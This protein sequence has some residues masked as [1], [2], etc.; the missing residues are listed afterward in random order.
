M[1]ESELLAESFRLHDG[2]T[3]YRLTHIPTG[4]AADDVG[5]DCDLPVVERWTRLRRELEKRLSILPR[6]HP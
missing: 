4:I 2:G 6:R 3:S 5:D 1:D